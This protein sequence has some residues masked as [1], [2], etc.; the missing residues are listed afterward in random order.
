MMGADLT[1]RRRRRAVLCSCMGA[2]VIV[3]TT[4]EAAGG[5]PVGRRDFV[6]G[7]YMERILPASGE[8]PPMRRFDGEDPSVARRANYGDQRGPGLTPEERRQL[9]RDIRDASRELYRDAPGR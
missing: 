1:S 4:V 8:L 6:G 3:A 5:E 7:Q 9:R 2:A